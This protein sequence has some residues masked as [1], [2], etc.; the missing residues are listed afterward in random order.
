MTSTTHVS[1][2]GA[3][4]RLLSEFNTGAAGLTVGYRR[5][6]DAHVVSADGLTFR[7]PA[8]LG[9]NGFLDP[10]NWFV[11]KHDG[12]KIHEPGLVSALLFLGA[13]LGQAETAFFDIGAL[14]GYF[15]VLAPVAFGNAEVHAVEPNPN[16]AAI[17]EAAI[18]KLEPAQ[19]PVRVQNVLVGTAHGRQWYDIDRFQF[20]PVTPRAALRKRLARAPKTLVRSL[21]GLGPGKHS[22]RRLD[23][24]P[25]AELVTRTDRADPRLILKLDT[26][27]YHAVFLPPATATLIERNAIVLLEFDGPPVMRAFGVSNFDL[28][29][30]F[31]KAGYTMLWMDHRSL[32]ATARLVTEASYDPA[33][34]TNSLAILLPPDFA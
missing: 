4:D 20:H 32:H 1:R 5:T 17:I 34:E 26:E 10:D 31:L 29:R 30:P 8:G 28:C 18:R 12:G 15:S 22:V 6:P 19:P 9:G 14:F 11:R 25:L 16:S 24:V 23:E 27:G 13:R 7:Y 3:A 33:I 2:S 21:T